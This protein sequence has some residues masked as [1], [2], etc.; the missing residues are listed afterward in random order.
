MNSGFPNLG[1]YIR[2]QIRAQYR[3]VFRRFQKHTRTLD[4]RADAVQIRHVLRNNIDC[5][6]YARIMLFSNELEQILRTSH[7]QTNTK[8]NQNMYKHVTMFLE[9]FAIIHNFHTP[10]A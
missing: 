10:T 2:R 3:G 9:S 4:L 5:R 6:L 8:V 7:Q 1:K